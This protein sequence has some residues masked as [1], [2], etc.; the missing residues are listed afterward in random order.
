MKDVGGAA[1]TRTAGRTEYR[2]NG[3]T[4]IILIVSFRLH[5]VRNILK[6]FV[7]T[8]RELFA[9]Q[10]LLIFFKKVYSTCGKVYIKC[11]VAVAVNLGPVAQN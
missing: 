5:R 9:L 1:E 10:N 8:M 2:T 7:E 3:R 6:R 11:N 4:R